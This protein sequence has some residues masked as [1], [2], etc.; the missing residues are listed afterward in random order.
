MPLMV[1]AG[2]GGDDIGRR[3]FHDTIGGKAISGFA[4]GD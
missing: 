4:Y 3:V 1:V 2:A